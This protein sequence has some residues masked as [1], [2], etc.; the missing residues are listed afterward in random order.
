MTARYVTAAACAVAALLIACGDEGIKA[1][2]A[3]CA[4]FNAADAA[5]Q[6]QLA[7]ELFEAKGGE[8]LPEDTWS[9]IK[10]ES[11]GMIRMSCT[12]SPSTPLADL[13]GLGAEAAGQA[14]QAPSETTEPS[15]VP[16]EDPT[17]PGD[18]GPADQFLTPRGTVSFTYSGFDYEAAIESSYL[19]VDSNAVVSSAK[20][21]STWLMIHVTLRNLH[22]DRAVP[23]IANPFLIHV[24]VRDAAAVSDTDKPCDGD[25]CSASTQ[26]GTATDG[27]LEGVPCSTCEIPASGAMTLVVAVAIKEGA[28]PE[29][30]RLFMRDTPSIM[31]VDTPADGRLT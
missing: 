25:Y 27:E 6:G 5:T 19:T 28:S 17:V 9:D 3:S 21:G 23:V 1:S 7:D 11:L 22:D 10:K 13:E 16:L 2:E 18:Q 14:A 20:P 30:I 4:D 26:L 8:R 12:A 31:T 15:G 29:D 24:G